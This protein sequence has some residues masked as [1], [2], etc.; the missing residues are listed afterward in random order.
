[1]MLLPAWGFIVLVLAVLI[2]V[3]GMLVRLELLVR[4]LDRCRKCDQHAAEVQVPPEIE[5]E[6]EPDQPEEEPTPALPL[7]VHHPPQIMR[8]VPKGDGPYAS[9]AC[10]KCG[11]AINP[12]EEFIWWPRPDLGLHMVQRFCMNHLKEMEDANG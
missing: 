10:H 8:Y 6:T 7:D 11:G 4:K 1:M 9:Y 3:A 2:A 5:E 12:G